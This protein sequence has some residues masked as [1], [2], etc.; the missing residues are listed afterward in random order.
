MRPNPFASLVFGATMAAHAQQPASQPLQTQPGLS[1]L[2][3]LA[4]QGNALLERAR[5]NNGSASITL[6]NYKGHHTMLSARTASGGAEQH[7]HFADFLIVLDGSGTELTGGTIV[8]LKS[9]ANGENV[10][11]RLEG[12]T[13]HALHKGDVLHIPA[14]TPHQAIEA[15]GETITIFVIKVEEPEG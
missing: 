2:A 11:P 5:A 12:G 9:R 14:G 6:S 13:P 4:A 15:P 1:N 8:D 3:S 10:G 7:M